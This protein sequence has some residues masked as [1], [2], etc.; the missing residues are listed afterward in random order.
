M[1]ARSSPAWWWVAAAVPDQAA[2]VLSADGTT[3]LVTAKVS[4]D[5]IEATAKADAIKPLAETRMNM[6]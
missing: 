5:D 4:G 6:M 3:A 2:S 1:T